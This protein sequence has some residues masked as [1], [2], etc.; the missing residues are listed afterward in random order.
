MTYLEVFGADQQYRIDYVY[1]MEGVRSQKSIEGVTHKYITQNGKVVQ[2]TWGTNVLQFVYDTNGSPY[3]MRYSTDSGS[4]WRTYY[5]V[6]NLQGDVVALI[7]ADGTVCATYSYNAWG[8]ILS[9]T[10][11][12]ASAVS[13]LAAINPLR[14]RGYYYDTETGW[15]YLQSRYYDPIV[16]RFINAD[17]YGSTG[18]GFLGYNMFAYCNNYPV[19]RSDPNGEFFATLVGAIGGAIGGFIGAAINGDDPLKGALIGAGTGALAGLAVDFAVATGGL[20]GVAIAVVGGAI[21]GGIDSAAN[22]IANGRSVDWGGAALSAGI[23][24]VTNLLSFGLVDSSALKSGGNIIKNFVS[25]GTKQLVANTTRKVAGKVV[26]KTFVGVA[27][28]VGK[29][30]LSNSVE[31]A[32]ISGFNGVFKKG[33]QAACQ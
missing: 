2:E 18:Q 23:G 19:A 4:S 17:S 15:Y 12:S 8:E 5:Y 27:K 22:D 30:I 33:I 6:L 20:G 24:G 10:T 29:N 9:A 16:K 3:A 11:T 13:N 26:S 21:A 31:A 7:Y 28:N 14:Y 1:D 32:I 25:N